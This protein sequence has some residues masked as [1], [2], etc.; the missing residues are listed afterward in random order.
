MPND[1]LGVA[2]GRKKR[3]QILI[4]T[5]IVGRCSFDWLREERSPTRQSPV[6]IREAVE[7][8]L[9]RLRTDYIDLYQLHWPDR[10]MRVFH[11]LEYVRIAGDTHPIPQILDTLAKL[12]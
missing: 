4:A 3:D 12:V 11:G 10:P 6:Q 7:A 1:R 2:L 5:K 8:S 9:K